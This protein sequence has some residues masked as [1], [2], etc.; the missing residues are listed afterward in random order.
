M[1]PEVFFKKLFEV[2]AIKIDT[3][4]EHGFKM[5]IHDTQPTAPLSP[6]YLNLRTPDN[7]KPG[8]LTP[9]LVAEIGR[10]FWDVAEESELAFDGICGIPN[11]GVPLAKAFDDA[12]FDDSNNHSPILTLQKELQNGVP[13]F[14]GVENNDG[15]DAINLEESRQNTILLIDDV[16]TYGGTKDGAV[17]A[18]IAEGYDIHNIL[19]FCDRQQGGAEHLQ[20]QGIKLESAF[21]LDNIVD[22]LRSIGVVSPADCAIVLKYLEQTHAQ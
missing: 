18:F 5:R 8:P 9:D 3:R 1:D 16:I 20:E 6:I 10:I 12:A 17:G 21:T 22:L 2:G 14:I 13:V 11:A 4:P 7:P 19:V 15:L